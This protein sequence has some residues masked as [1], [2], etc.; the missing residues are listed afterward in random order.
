MQR[1]CAWTASSC[2]RSRI[3][4]RPLSSGTGGAGGVARRGRAWIGGGLL[5][6]ADR[7]DRHPVAGLHTASGGD[8]GLAPGDVLFQPLTAWGVMLRNGIRMAGKV[9]AKADAGLRGIIG[10]DST[11][12]AGYSAIGPRFD[13][14]TEATPKTSM[15]H[16]RNRALL[17]CV[18]D[19]EP[20]RR[21]LV[22]SLPGRG[23]ETEPRD[24]RAA[25]HAAATDFSRSD[26]AIWF[27]QVCISTLCV[28]SVKRV[29][30]LRDREWPC[31]AVYKHPANNALL[32]ACGSLRRRMASA[33]SRCRGGRSGGVV[34]QLRDGKMPARAMQKFTAR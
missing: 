23:A 12:L 2:D 8:A 26:S 27:V 5:L 20:S 24:L 7:P 21:A 13:G 25:A 33:G 1:G 14:E 15:P 29:R 10:A 16:S 31:R 22:R 9:H 6:G 28:K 30:S 32:S 34:G 19:N 18:S 4:S 3:H 17:H 11:A